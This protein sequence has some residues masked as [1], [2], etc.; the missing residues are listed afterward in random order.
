MR[1]FFQKKEVMIVERQK[2]I[3]AVMQNRDSFPSVLMSRLKK[4][5][6]DSVDNAIPII[7]RPKLIAGVKKIRSIFL[8][9]FFSERN[10]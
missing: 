3:K 2:L 8:F 10:G 5:F 4:R 7:V 1:I 6:M 9:F